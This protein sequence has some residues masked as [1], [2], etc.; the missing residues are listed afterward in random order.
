MERKNGKR[1]T[2][3]SRKSRVKM[4]KSGK[5]WV[6]TV[7]SQIGLIQLGKRSASES[8]KIKLTS[9]S[10]QE[11]AA[12]M[13]RGLVAASAVVG[14]GLTAEQVLAEDTVI[15][16]EVTAS[17]LA[18]EDT[19][20][21]SDAGTESDTSSQSVSESESTSHSES[22]SDSES[23]SSS[24]SDSISAST[25]ESISESESI[26]FSEST[27]SSESTIASENSQSSFT[28][29]ELSESSTAESTTSEE[30][31]QQVLDQVVSEAEILIRIAE[32]KLEAAPDSDLA[33]A[34]A[35]SR[36]NLETAKQL[37]G[38][39]NA[40]TTDI[41]TITSALQNS[42][43][44][45]G[46]E[47]LKNEEDGIIT[48]ALDTSTTVTLKV[49]TG[50][51]VLFAT[52]SVA[53]PAMTDANGAKISDPTNTTTFTPS[54]E[55]ERFTFNY[56]KLNWFADQLT[57][58]TVKE[59][60]YFRY[61]LD[62]DSSTSTTYVE[63]V[64]KSTNTVVESHTLDK[65]QQATFTYFQ[66][67][68]GANNLPLVVSYGDSTASSTTAGELQVLYNGGTVTN[69]LVPT[70]Q[71][72]TTYYKTT[73]G[74]TIATY[75]MMGIGGQMA[76][77]S[78]VRTF[79]GYD[80]ASKTGGETVRLYSVGTLYNDGA[81]ASS[82]IK[83]LAEVVSD[84][85]DV[86]K[87]IWLKDP[88]YTGTVDYNS[89]DTTGFIKV[90]E[91]SVMSP[92]TY[93]TS[94]VVPTNSII[95]ATESAQ[96]TANAQA[97]KRDNDIFVTVYEDN[98]LSI[99]IGFDGYTKAASGYSYASSILVQTILKTTHPDYNPNFTTVNPNTKGVTANLYNGLT[100]NTVNETTYYYTIDTSESIS[101]SNSV[102]VSES[103]SSSE[104]TSKSESVSQSISNSV[105]ESVH[106]SVSESIS[107]SVSESISESVSESV[108]ESLSESVSESISESVSESIS[109][110]TSESISE[111]VS[112]S[113]S[114]SVSESL[115]ESVS[116]S[117]SESVSES[118]SEST[119][120]SISESV[121]ESISESVS[122]SISE[123]VSESISES[124][125]ESI[126][127]SVS[128]SISE[129]VSESISESVSESISES[130]SES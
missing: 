51:G 114:E 90:M 29:S 97:G 38:N 11:S 72:Y 109:E 85:G 55:A 52:T 125:S 117:I 107:E 41:Q 33:V 127:E 9:A 121:S 12:K 21:M 71:L 129:S 45:L 88:T 39:S 87:S 79:T 92:G 74:T 89:A 67:Y 53:N 15:A 62:Y 120:E 42:S 130:V 24:E 20:S 46:L 113:I 27:S 56:S 1:Y 111:S 128:E 81:I 124:T 57:D 82:Y 78:G 18:N 35:V 83:R 58:T 93:N 30:T 14:G 60:Y 63:L 43:Q 66:N 73:D 69:T 61:S 16:T 44:L 101:I 36:T 13:L 108:S 75:T 25:S 126:S 34:V 54:S 80:Y 106:E 105:S 115:S 28:T 10:Q 95:N 98:Y 118:I 31:P 91:T 5:H 119:S 68:S 122:E 7:M 26:S 100:S 49:G 8:P 110:S 116:E 50:Q 4:H 77:P 40:T 64:N 3:V 19:I 48:Y 76:T 112:E 2:E 32:S 22:I 104:S 96:I 65:G 123:S 86:I 59:N 102:S 94:L 103:V 6:R 23:I 37:L 84:D 99:R 70:Y 47:L 17:V